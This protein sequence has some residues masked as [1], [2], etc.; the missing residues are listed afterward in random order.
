MLETYLPPCCADIC[1]RAV[2]IALQST[3]MYGNKFY[4]IKKNNRTRHSQI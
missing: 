2:I 1:L 4:K 3:L